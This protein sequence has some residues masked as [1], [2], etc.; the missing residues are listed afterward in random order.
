L[1]DAHGDFGDDAE[2]P[3]GADDE[4]Q[5]I[6]AF[7]IEIGAADLAVDNPLAGHDRPQGGDDFGSSGKNGLVDV[8]RFHRRGPYRGFMEFLTLA[9]ALAKAL[10]ARL[11]NLRLAFASASPY[12]HAH[13]TRGSR[14][15]DSRAAPGGFFL[16]SRQTAPG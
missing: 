3:L 8:H 12:K 15:P 4:A 9:E 10:R 16:W 7:G 13:S 2:H 6:I 1:Q 14:G 5:Q 11:S